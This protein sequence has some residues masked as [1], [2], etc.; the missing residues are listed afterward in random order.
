MRQEIE[1]YSIDMAE[2]GKHLVMGPQKKLLRELD[3]INRSYITSTYI[4]GNR[5]VLDPIEPIGV[6]RTYRWKRGFKDSILKALQTRFLQY[7]K[8]GT[9]E[10]ILRNRPARMKWTRREFIDKILTIEDQMKELRSRKVTMDD[11]LD[12]G[13]NRYELLMKTIQDKMESA[14]KIIPDMCNV[15]LDSYIAFNEV[16]DD[17]YLAGTPE[18]VE[19]IKWKTSVFT[20]EV[21]YNKPSI[22]IMNKEGDIVGQI[23]TEPIYLFFEL[24]MANMVDAMFAHDI[25]NLDGQMI[26]SNDR[27]RVTSSERNLY[28]VQAWPSFKMKGRWAGYNTSNQYDNQITYN[29]PFFSQG[30]ESLRTQTGGRLNNYWT[31]MT[32]DGNGFNSGNNICFGNLNDEIVESVVRLDFMRLFTALNSWQIYTLGV[33]Q[34]LQSIHKSILCVDDSY[35]DTFITDVGL[36]INLMYARYLNQINVDYDIA[37]TLDD[38]NTDESQKSGYYDDV[39]YSSRDRYNSAVL[40]Y[41]YDYDNIPERESYYGYDFTRYE[42]LPTYETVKHANNIKSGE[43]ELEFR[44]VMMQHNGVNQMEDSDMDKADQYITTCQEYIL[45]SMISLVD[46]LDANNCKSRELSTLYVEFVE[47]IDKVTGDDNVKTERKVSE[48]NTYIANQADPLSSMTE[49]G[50]GLSDRVYERLPFDER[51]SLNNYFHEEDYL[52]EEE[53]QEEEQE[54][55]TDMSMEDRMME[56]AMRGIRT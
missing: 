10:A 41:A 51:A 32:E 2:V 38:S 45:N 30:K 31:S 6:T 50:N 25:K 52:G 14:K 17:E 53:E 3:R 26:A 24:P 27:Y 49:D 36:P 35:S 15:E 56:V 20:L 22:T 46:W 16:T 7:D 9:L 33:T 42:W 21:K 1:D 12:T 28:G 8:P 37:I 4:Y 5:S 11:T 40:W 34:P 55:T 43:R 54:P 13:V 29:H 19:V 44:N 47:F 39:S 48:L 18:K 23:P